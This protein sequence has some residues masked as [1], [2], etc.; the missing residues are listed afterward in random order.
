MIAI[1]GYTTMIEAEV[2]RAR[3][4]DAGIPASVG[5]WS[6]MREFADYRVLVDDGRAA[7]AAAFLGLAPPAPQPPLP[8]WVAPVGLALAAVVLALA[9][10]ALF[11]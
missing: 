5:D 7:E 9:V 2:V 6:A 3:L 4:E 11:D 1:A 8:S 10:L